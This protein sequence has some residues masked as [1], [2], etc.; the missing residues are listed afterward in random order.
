[1]TTHVVADD[2]LGGIA[3]KQWELSRRLM[4]GSLDPVIVST[5]LQEI[6]EGK[7]G[8]ARYPYLLDPEEQF[9]LILR[10]NQQVSIRFALSIL[11]QTVYILNV[12]VNETSMIR[13]SLDISPP[14]SFDA[15]F[16]NLCWVPF[17]ATLTSVC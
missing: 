2:V 7:I 6:I 10:Y 14:S 17:M 3:R 15:V 11:L 4:E 1:M 12:F 13:Q 5:G 8:F 16:T 9:E